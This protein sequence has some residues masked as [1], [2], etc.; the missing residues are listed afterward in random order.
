MSEIPIISC[1]NDL[2]YDNNTSTN[3]NFNS[4]NDDMYPISKDNEFQITIAR[5]LDEAIAVMNKYKDLKIG[6]YGNS[7]PNFNSTRNNTNSIAYN[8]NGNYANN[9]Y[10]NNFHTTRTPETHGS[11]Y[12]VS[13]NPLSS[14]NMSSE[15]STYSKFSSISESNVT[16]SQTMPA[17]NSSHVLLSGLPYAS[18]YSNPLVWETDDF[19]TKREMLCKSTLFICVLLMSINVRILI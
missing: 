14:L 2:H 11:N 10:S 6:S 12:S 5:A 15:R 16:N 18:N 1:Q 13:M 7:I 3:H 4:N 19:E 9:S 17:T 8:S